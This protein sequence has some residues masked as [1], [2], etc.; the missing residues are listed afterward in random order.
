MQSFSFEV[1]VVLRSRQE[2]LV[3]VSLFGKSECSIAV[4]RAVASAVFAWMMLTRDGCCDSSLLLSACKLSMVVVEEA[5]T[6][7][8][9]ARSLP[10]S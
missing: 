8:M 7:W 1:K 6:N 4:I 10:A 9:I 2:G 5:M 3:Q